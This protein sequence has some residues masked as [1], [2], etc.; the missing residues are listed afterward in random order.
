MTTQPLIVS[1]PFTDAAMVT[2]EK[3]RDL[4]AVMDASC[5]TPGKKTR[6]DTYRVHRLTDQTIVRSLA[7]L[8][9]SDDSITW[10]DEGNCDKKR[11]QVAEAAVDLMN[12]RV[13]PPETTCHVSLEEEE[14]DEEGPL[15]ELRTPRKIQR[16]Q[17]GYW[18]ICPLT[19]APRKKLSQKTRLCHISSPDMT[20][21]KKTISFKSYLAK[22]KGI[23]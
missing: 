16:I 17:M 22:T 12:L 6:Q 14:E 18:S 13:P 3:T 21:V 5:R 23:F 2:P 15:Q 10:L 8:S 7:K 20:L 19:M 11:T 4:N 1:G 9:F